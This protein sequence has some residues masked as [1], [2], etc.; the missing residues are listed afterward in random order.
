[1]GKLC[2]KHVCFTLVL[3]KKNNV[4]E[5]KTIDLFYV[6]M[7]NLKLTLRKLCSGYSKIQILLRFFTS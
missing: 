7:Y 5:N 4:N 3:P 2:T 1:M 6:N